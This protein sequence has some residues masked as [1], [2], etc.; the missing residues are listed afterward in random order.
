VARDEGLEGWLREEGYRVAAPEEDPVW[1]VAA[2]IGLLGDVDAVDGLRVED[3]ELAEEAGGL[4]VVDFQPCVFAREKQH[5][6]GP[7]VVEGQGGH[8]AEAIA[9]LQPG[10]GLALGGVSECLSR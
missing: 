10:D 6:V 9:V 1:G 3:L 7:G 5:M 8:G 4:D 2:V